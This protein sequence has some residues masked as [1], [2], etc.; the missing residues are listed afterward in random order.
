VVVVPVVVAHGNLADLRLILGDTSIE[1]TLIH[2]RLTDESVPA[3]ALR[4]WQSS[5]AS[6]SNSIGNTG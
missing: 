1:T 5:D 2:A 4:V 6:G 3:A